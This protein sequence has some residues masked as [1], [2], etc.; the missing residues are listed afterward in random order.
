MR[1]LL[2]GF[3]SRHYEQFNCFFIAIVEPPRDVIIVSVSWSHVIL[4]WTSPFSG[5][6]VDFADSYRVE[7]RT[8]KEK[9]VVITTK[10]HARIDGLKQLTYY[11]LN[12]QAWNGLGYGPYLDTDLHFRT[13]G[14]W[15]SVT[16]PKLTDLFHTF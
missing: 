15:G 1:S 13:P 5:T 16:F 8:N 6:A 10:T 14:N 7:A 12:V 2:N 3:P 4:N 9:I 11:L